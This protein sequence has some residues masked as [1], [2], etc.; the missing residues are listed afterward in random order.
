MSQPWW[1]IACTDEER[2]TTIQ[3]VEDNSS[4]G[5]SYYILLVLSTLIAAY[6]LI[7]NS[8]AT[9]IGAMIVAPLMG[10]ILGLGLA[11]VRNDSRT[12]YKA[13]TAEV[14]GVFIVIL[15]GAAVAGLVSTDNIDFGLS[16]IA[17]RTR[18]TLYDLAIGLAAGLAGAYC[19]VH[20]ALQA[21][22]AG[23]AIAVALVPPLAVT[24]ITAAGALHGYVS[25]AESLGSFMLFFANFLTIEAAAIVIFIM[26][27]MGKWSDVA[28]RRR[29]LAVKAL[30][31]FMTGIFLYQQLTNLVRERVGLYH[32]RQALR[33]SLGQIP[34]ANLDD[35]NVDL[36]R[37]TLR[38]NAVV[39]SRNEIGPELVAEMQQRIQ[40]ELPPRLSDVKAE[41][42]VRTVNSTY[43]SAEGLL[44]EPP[45]S[46]GP[47]PEQLRLQALESTLKAALASHPPAELESFREVPRGEG[48]SDLLLTVVN[49]YPMRPRLVSQLEEQLAELIRVEPSLNGQTFHLTVRTLVV[50]SATSK[51]D[52]EFTRPDTTTDEERKRIEFERGVRAALDTLVAAESGARLLEA[53]VGFPSG[54]PA[55]G[56]PAEYKVRA[57]VQGPR[58]L[59]PS[60]VSDW[61]KALT[62]ALSSGEASRSFNLEIESVVGATIQRGAADQEAIKEAQLERVSSNLRTQVAAV[63]NAFISEAPTSSVESVG[64]LV[65]V[66]VRVGV[67]TPTPLKLQLVKRW[68]K[69]LALQEK[70]LNPKVRLQLAVE[71]QLG[72]LLNEQPKPKPKPEPIPAIKP[73]PR[74]T[75]SATPTP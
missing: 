42:I 68:E 22:V 24:G 51:R 43:A 65:I 9:V 59:E 47:N 57:T 19:T 1:Q 18:P 62:Q 23:V 75:P 21:S 3:R 69:S 25:W 48:E 4:P 6:G 14:S 8:T 2:R 58:L 34:G 32:T 26:A 44:F 66:R 55:E 45:K 29:T 33:M 46:T 49:A 64:D 35:L 56:V 15:T 63:K 11:M 28:K 61:E 7:S 36:R 31:L 60:T 71:N 16:E 67:V 54:E 70:A 73:A 39:G 50:Q 10:P 53:H 27:G 41:L 74:V 13:L 17:G 30:L 5:P 52:V 20:P 40:D 38:V 72:S 12:F 37:S